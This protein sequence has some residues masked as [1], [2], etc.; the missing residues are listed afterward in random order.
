M[1]VYQDKAKD[2]VRTTLPKMRRI[3]DRGIENNIKEADTRQVVTR[4]VSDMLGWDEFD[5]LTA[6]QAIS[7]GFADF[8]IQKENSKNEMEKL[9]VIEVKSLGTKLNENHLRQARGYAM[10]EGIEFILL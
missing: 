10:D 8:V 7:G 6:E 4:V 2:R 1:A 3:I 5:N 9:A